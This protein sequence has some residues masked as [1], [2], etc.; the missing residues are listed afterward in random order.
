MSAAVT[1]TWTFQGGGFTYYNLSWVFA[2]TGAQVLQMAGANTFNSYNATITSIGARTI[3]WAASV[4]QTV[5]SSLTLAGTASNVLTI[6][7][8]LSGTYG[9]LSCPLG[10]VISV[11][12]VSVK[13][14]RAFGTAAPFY[15]TG[16]ST[17]V[18]NAPNWSLVGG[19]LSLF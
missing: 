3:T 15:A 8:S 16:K 18:S 9:T 7:S 19:L 11:T 5:T 14:N 10:A 17:I 2:N 13:D 12:N 1:G 4:T 6:N